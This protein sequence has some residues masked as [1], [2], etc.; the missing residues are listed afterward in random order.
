MRARQE[1]KPSQIYTEV[2]SSLCFGDTATQAFLFGDWSVMAAIF[3]HY[4][5]TRFHVR[6]LQ[7]LP[8][9]RWLEDRISLFNKYALP[10]I[11]NQ[12]NQNFT[13]LIAVSESTPKDVLQ[14]FEQSPRIEL[15]VTPDDA[16]VEKHVSQMRERVLQSRSPWVIT[17]R[18]DSDDA[19]STDYVNTVQS[20]FA[21]QKKGINFAAGWVYDPRRDL[22]MQVTNWCNQFISLVEPRDKSLKTV[23]CRKHKEMHLE[24]H[25]DDSW[26]KTRWMQVAHGGNALNRDLWAKGRVIPNEE[27]LEKFPWFLEAQK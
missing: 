13:W 1:V 8:G 2:D 24:C 18:L 6:V 4:L 23:Y 17:T 27:I 12:D 26:S 19:I 22:C 21:P 11:T 20:R 3:T 15:I 9:R 7:Q 25:V 14:I 16:P 10:S 5:L